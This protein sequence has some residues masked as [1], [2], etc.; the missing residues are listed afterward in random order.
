MKPETE[1]DRYLISLD[2]FTNTNRS[3]K[4]NSKPAQH[5]AP[6][7][8]WSFRKKN[9]INKEIVLSVYSVMLLPS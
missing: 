1:R 8:V 4:Q 5:R 3:L 6:N 2:L 9:I 7:I